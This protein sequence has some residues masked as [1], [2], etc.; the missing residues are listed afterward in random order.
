MPNQ[1]KSK[2]KNDIRDIMYIMFEFCDASF[3]EYSKLEDL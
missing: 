3:I 1:S 2:S